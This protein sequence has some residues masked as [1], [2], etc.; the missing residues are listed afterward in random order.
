MFELIYTSTS[1][2]L[3]PGRSG[4][5][6]VAWTEGIPVNLVAPLE[7]LSAYKPLFS[8]HHPEAE[9]NPVAFS[10]LRYR[11]GS[12]LLRVVSRIGFAGL[13]YTGRSNKIAHHLVFESAGELGALSGGA[14]GV[15][16]SGEIFLIRWEEPARLLPRRRVRS[17]P[18]PDGPAD[19]WRRQ[20]G[21]PGWAGVIAGIFLREPGKGFFLEFPVGSDPGILLQLAAEVAKLLPP[22]RLDDFTFSTYFTQVPAGCECFLRMVPTGSPLLASVRRFQPG[23]VLTL[24]V[25][26]AIPAEWETSPLVAAARSGSAPAAVQLRETGA[27]S[28]PPERRPD[29]GAAGAPDDLSGEEETIPLRDI[30]AVAEVTSSS[31][32]GQEESQ[33]WEL[34]REGR[35]AWLRRCFFLLPVG[36]VLALLIAGGI[37]FRYGNPVPEESLTQVE[38]ELLPPPEPAASVSIPAVPVIPAKPEPADV[39]PGPAAPVTPPGQKGSPEVSG[40]SGAASPRDSDPGLRPLSARE[41]LALCREWRRMRAVAG[42]GKYLIPLP[43]VLAAATRLEIEVDGSGRV[44]LAESVREGF[45]RRRDEFCVELLPVRRVQASPEVAAKYVPDEE[46]PP[47]ARLSVML[48]PGG[49]RLMVPA[50]AD[51]PGPGNLKRLVFR[52]GRTRVDWTPEFSEAY[53]SGIRSGRVTVGAGWKPAFLPSEEEEFFAGDFDTLVG[54]VS[55]RDFANLPLDRRIAEWNRLLRESETLETR[56]AAAAG[57]VAQAAGGVPQEGTAGRLRAVAEQIRKESAGKVFQAVLGQMRALQAELFSLAA[58][59]RE[60]EARKLLDE[61]RGLFDEFEKSCVGFNLHVKEGEVQLPLEPLQALRE[62]SS[63]FDRRLREW[64][65]RAAEARQLQAAAEALPRELERFREEFRVFLS[66][67]SPRL[68]HFFDDELNGAK[69]IADDENRRNLFASRIM[70]VHRMRK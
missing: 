26:T 55:S 22:G 18:L 46:S 32:D 68:E 36:A 44:K 67:I 5:A 34:S 30:P 59:G 40:P 54:G 25:A 21:D 15:A 41:G 43:E 9:K 13:D 16:R 37:L 10:Y 48:V 52:D 63:T 39:V 6:S 65:V 42:G 31:G 61:L 38:Q 24:G 53:L 4:F 23:A 60:A 66:G 14:I 27:V 69:P 35:S 50:A 58:Y 57:A 12:T 1:A 7:G 49:L 28:P 17:L 3:I 20:T 11:Y 56:A 51:G 47:G 45:L 62:E 8:A 29:A 64:R 33:E 70:V 2:G 19:A